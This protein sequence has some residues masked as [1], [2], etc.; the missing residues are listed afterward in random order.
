MSGYVFIFMR[1]RLWR[2]QEGELKR[3]VDRKT[4]DTDTAAKVCS[5]RRGRPSDWRYESASLYLT[6][7]GSWFIA[8]GGGPLS[9]WGVREAGSGDHRGGEGLLPVNRQEALA[10]LENIDSEESQLAIQEHFGDLIEAA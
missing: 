1:C 10:W 8:G 2:S 9:S 6:Q 3:T 5:V 4:Y 7:K